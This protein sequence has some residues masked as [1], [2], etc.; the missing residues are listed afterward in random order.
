MDGIIRTIQNEG[1]HAE[2]IAP[3]I[4]MSKVLVI[5]SNVDDSNS[6]GED[7]DMEWHGQMEDR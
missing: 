1:Y 2:E 5:N 4:R 7:L 6:T 3:I